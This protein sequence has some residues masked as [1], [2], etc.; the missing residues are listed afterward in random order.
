MRLVPLSADAL[1]AL[2]AGDLGRAGV[3]V[4]A[5]VP[6]SFR[7]EAWLWRLRLDQL[8]ADPAAAPWLVRAAVL[9]G[10]AAEAAGDRVVGHAGFHGPPDADGAVEVGY[11]VDPGWRGR[12]LG[13]ALLAALLAEASA[14][15]VTTVRASVSPRNAPS[16][17][18]VRAAGFVQVGEQVDEDDGPE[19]VFARRPGGAGSG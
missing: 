3:L 8:T 10:G 9:A 11:T 15:G 7:D 16:L 17:A 14:A 12:G 18:V 13:H 5:P 1:R 19:L 4:R 2:L 6:G